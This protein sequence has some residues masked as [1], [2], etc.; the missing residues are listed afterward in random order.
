MIKS[1]FGCKCSTP[2]FLWDPAGKMIVEC[3]KLK[4]T[5][6][7]LNHCDVCEPGLFF[8]NQK[9]VLGELEVKK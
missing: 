4:G 9:S 8:S 2:Q 3:S 6:P 1:C 5:F 7:E